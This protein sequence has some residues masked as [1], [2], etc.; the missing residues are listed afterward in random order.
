MKRTK[1]V[2]LALIGG[3][4]ALGIF[5]LWMIGRVG[6]RAIE[7][8]ETLPNFLRTEALK[9]LDHQGHVWLEDVDSNGDGQPE[10]VAYTPRV[11]PADT[12]GGAIAFDRLVLMQLGRR[13]GR[14]LLIVDHRGIRDSMG[15]SLIDQVEAA[16]GYRALSTGKGAD[17]RLHLTLLDSTGQPASDELTL[18]Y[19]ASS[20]AFVVVAP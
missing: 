12:S 6:N 2:P 7:E 9:Y 20:R 11:G 5:S 15:R 17:F 16:H 14:P 4:L 18:G 19:S 1:L 13:K 3:V 8:A 10:V